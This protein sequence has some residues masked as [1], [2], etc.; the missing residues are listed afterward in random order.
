[1]NKPIRANVQA[2]QFRR[3]RGF[4]MIAL[5]HFGDTKKLR[6]GRVVKTGKAPL[7]F[8]W[9]KRPLDKGVIARC[10]SEN[11]NM[12]WRIPADALVLDVDPRNGG[13]AGFADLAMDYGLDE[14]KFPRVDTGSGGFHLYGKKPAGLAIVDTLEAYKG[15]EFK[16]KGRQVVAAGSIHPDT[17][18]PYTFNDSN[19]AIEDGLPEFPADL[20]EAIAR[21]DRSGE[22]IGGGQYTQEQLARALAKLNAEDFRDYSKWLQLAMACHHA[23]NGD[24]REEF[25]EW[26]TH[27]LEICRR[28]RR[29]RPQ[30]GWLP[31]GPRLRSHL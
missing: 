30:V 5:H 31:R 3:Y 25:V 14:S 28:W 18:K 12:G 22:V 4:D 27:R 10:I 7:D 9:T 19:P 8:N 24:G 26:S 21:P 2:D 20:L 13:V 16:S 6:N 17:L 29:D 1:M 23:T 11:R 15:V